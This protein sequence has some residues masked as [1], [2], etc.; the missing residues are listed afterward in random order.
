MFDRAST[1]ENSHLPSVEKGMAMTIQ[2]IKILGKAYSAHLY[3]IYGR[4]MAP[5]PEDSAALIVTI[6]PGWDR[7]FACN[8]EGT[9]LKRCGKCKLA[10]YCSI[11]CQKADWLP[12]HK[13]NCLEEKTVMMTAYLK[14][15]KADLSKE[16]A[17]PT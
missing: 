9:D 16:R 15:A 12:S 10:T 1:T 5:D 17:R 11:A 13:A 7:C 4:H 14:K 2:D 3:Q 8:K 6:G